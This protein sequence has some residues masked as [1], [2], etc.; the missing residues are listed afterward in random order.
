MWPSKNSFIY[1]SWEF[2]SA[3]PGIAE[4]QKN[5]RLSLSKEF[6]G[7][8]ICTFKAGESPRDFIIA[9]EAL[10]KPLGYKKKI[11]LCFSSAFTEDFLEPSQT[12]KLEIFAEIFNCF[13]AFT[14]FAATF[15][16][17]FHWFLNTSLF[18]NRTCSFLSG[19][20][21]KKKKMSKITNFKINLREATEKWPNFQKMIFFLMQIS[22]KPSN[23]DI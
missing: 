11:N 18:Y 16:E 10:I 12:S 22:P 8:N 2:S 14:I 5:L 3:Q 21:F 15:S 4:A 13:K 17:M 23:R 9:V 1:R 20:N 7:K 19:Q 6:A